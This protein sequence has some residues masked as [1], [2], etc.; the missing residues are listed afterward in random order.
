MQNSVLVIHGAGTPALRG[1]HIYWQTL[2]R[3]ELG[4][5]YDVSCPLMP[6]ADHP[7]HRNWEAGIAKAMAGSEAVL[8]L[9]HSL[10]ASSLLKFLSEHTSHRPVRA[11][12]L[13]STPDWGPPGG[14]MDEFTLA[15][16][17][18]TRLPRCPTFLYHSRHDTE[19][20]LAHLKRYQRELPWATARVIEGERHDFADGLFPELVHDI[21]DVGRGSVRRA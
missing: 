3:A 9:G 5:G 4:D 14:D 10:G 15:P 1:G 6:D 7:R 21:R 17:F 2:L 20:P 19:I 8:L 18:A 11:L 16:D 13:V 12:F